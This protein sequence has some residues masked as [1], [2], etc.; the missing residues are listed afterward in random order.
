MSKEHL[1]YS[2]CVDTL[3]YIHQMLGDEAFMEELAFIRHKHLRETE[4]K[5]EAVLSEP[6]V[7]LLPPIA[8]PVIVSEPIMIPVTSSTELVAPSVN[9]TKNVVI[10]SVAE[11]K[12][13][14]VRAPPPD[15][16]RCTHLVR[17]GERCI[18][19]RDPESVFCSRHASKES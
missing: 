1:T 10:T 8:A 17:S 5:S 12:E 15:E 14:H 2:F 9:S 13:K 19:K 3:R 4:K 7:S 6:S 16:S 18:F 11:K